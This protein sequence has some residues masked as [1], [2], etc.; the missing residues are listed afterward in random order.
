M[1]RSNTSHNAELCIGS[2]FIRGFVALEISPLVT[3]THL[4]FKG[5]AFDLRYY[6]FRVSFVASRDVKI[7]PCAI[8]LFPHSYIVLPQGHLDARAFQF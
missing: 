2:L 6:C 7:A 1:L 8:D 5:T 4:L 3:L